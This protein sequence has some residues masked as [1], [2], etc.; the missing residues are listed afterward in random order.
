MA[1]ESAHSSRLIVSVDKAGLS[2][3][4]TILPG[5]EEEIPSDLELRADGGQE[6]RPPERM[7]V[8]GAD[9]RE[10]GGGE[11]EPARGAR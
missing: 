11:D 10:R 4:L 7:A 1:D 8:E 6:E 9:A 5:R 2:C 3:T